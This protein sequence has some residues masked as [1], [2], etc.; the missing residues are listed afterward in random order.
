MD[1]YG[2]GQTFW[3]K[4]TSPVTLVGVVKQNREHHHVHEILLTTVLQYKLVAQMDRTLQKL[5]HQHYQIQMSHVELVV[6]TEK[7]GRF[8][9]KTDFQDVSRSDKHCCSSA[10]FLCRCGRTT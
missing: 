3:T 1:K 4:F 7:D 10:T 5:E 2:Y 8:R 9:E 6:V